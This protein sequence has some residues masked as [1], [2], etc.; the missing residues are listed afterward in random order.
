MQFVL[1]VILL[2]A[3]VLSVFN[4]CDAKVGLRSMLLKY[5]CDCSEGGS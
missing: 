1:S 4:N 2:V 3:N 5:V